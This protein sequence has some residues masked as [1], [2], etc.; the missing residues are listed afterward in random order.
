MHLLKGALLFG[1]IILIGTGWTFFKNFLV[2]RDRKLFMIVIP[3]QVID[4]IAL[5][6]L[7]ESEQGQQSYQFWTRF[8]IFIDLLCCAAIIF[9]VIWSI[10]HLEEASHTDGK[11]AFNLEKLK[12]FRQFYVIIICYI[13]LTRILKYL[14]AFTIPF[15]YKW[16]TVAIEELGSLIFY[17]LT[18]YKFK[19]A[20]NNPYLK[21][22]STDVQEMSIA[23]V[24]HS[25]PLSSS[26]LPST[27]FERRLVVRRLLRKMVLAKTLFMTGFVLLT[28]Q[29]ATASLDNRRRSS[30][31][32]ALPS[33][34]FVTAR[35]A[36]PPRKAT[37]LNC[38]DFNS[39]CRWHNDRSVN[40]INWQVAYKP[41]PDSMIRTLT[42][43]QD[44]PDGKFLMARSNVRATNGESALLV[45][46]VIPCQNNQGFLTLRYWATRRVY[47]Q[48]CTR[49][50]GTGKYYLYC[51]G[52]F[53]WAR[54]SV[55]ETIVPNPGN[56][57]FE[58]VIEATNF[59]ANTGKQRGGI[60]MID[61]IKY[62]ACLCGSALRMPKPPKSRYQIVPTRYVKMHT[63]PPVRQPVTYHLRHVTRPAAVTS[64][65]APPVN[66]V[67]TTR[68][69]PPAVT[70]PADFTWPE[71]SAT[72]AVAISWPER[73]A[74]TI[75]LTSWPEPSPVEAAVTA[76]LEVTKGSHVYKDIVAACNAIKCDFG[77]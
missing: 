9:P 21:L 22:D 32:M 30:I 1:T 74:T 28:L 23:P 44:V 26:H 63:L 42:R 5:I 58:I 45:S 8:F 65:P 14:I 54:Y 6:V 70:P 20:A 72:T 47:I 48:V 77:T 60:A 36:A 29:N 46:D 52:P 55:A 71:D 16:M 2:D 53:K 51:S 76:M 4:N 49:R 56:E 39:H 66:A 73:N 64:R 43:S 27:D 40:S 59:V 12:L 25:M 15:K 67:V 75:A 17:V 38:A 69:G 57:P 41:F 13:Y 61:D 68:R 35:Q 3:L 7:E 37:D 11:A 24:S 34:A 31:G 62:S 50:P 18:G 19:P 10:K 33:K